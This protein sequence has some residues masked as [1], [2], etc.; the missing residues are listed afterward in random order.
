METLQL[1]GVALG[2]SALAGINLYLTVFATG[3]AIHQGWIALASQ[4][5]Q[6]AILGD[7]WIWGIAGAL[8]IIEFVADK[9][10]WVDSAWDAVHTV[11]RPVGGAFLA[12]KALGTPDPMFDILIALLAGGVS[13]T[14][15]ATKAGTRLLVNTSP[16]PFS[17]VMT[18]IG[19][20]VLVLG[21]LAM[22]NWNPG[23]AFVV[24]FAIIVTLLWMA[25]KI[26]RAFRATLWMFWKK[27]QSPAT[28]KTKVELLTKLPSDADLSLAKLTTLSE[29]VEWAA[30]CLSG[31]GVR[32][33][34][35]RF[36]YLTATKEEPNRVYF[37]GKR[38]AVEIDTT[39]LR[40]AHEPRFLSEEVVLYS[41][42]S[43]KKYVFQFNRSQGRTA[44]AVFQALSQR[45]GAAPEKEEDIQALPAPA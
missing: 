26:Y 1:L 6:L 21:G 36:G 43:K 33:G 4:H 32:A 19:E 41:R 14:T 25:P 30:F 40:V 8:Y 28:D 31:R 24:F 17:N 44:E 3:F 18:S 5:H 42:T 22:I 10:P 29:T 27:L 39:D 16:E 13:L 11:I 38:I 7:P 23:V 34:S 12:V 20:D 9:V 35:N 15:H 37:V 45:I 2:L